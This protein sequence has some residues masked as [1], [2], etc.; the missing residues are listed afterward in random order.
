MILTGHIACKRDMRYA[1]RIIVGK[2][3]RKRPLPRS[4][5]RWED[6][7]KLDVK[8]SG[9]RLNRLKMTTILPVP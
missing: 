1:Y 2:P 4:K 3:V 9:V 6:N 8:K 7:I 5:Y